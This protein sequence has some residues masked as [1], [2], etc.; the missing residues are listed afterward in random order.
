MGLWASVSPSPGHL[1][2]ETDP[3]G[4]SK[5]RT[6]PMDFTSGGIHVISV[7]LHSPSRAT[8][9]S[10]QNLSVL[11]RG[12]GGCACL[13]VC[14]VCFKKKSQ[15]VHDRMFTNADASHGLTT[16]SVWVCIIHLF[17]GHN[18]TYFTKMGT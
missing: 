1:V 13:R 2:W 4:V 17:W 11:G 8:L 15:C 12:V 10:K 6:G 14:V 3:T 18:L 7:C 16:V 9:P 5:D